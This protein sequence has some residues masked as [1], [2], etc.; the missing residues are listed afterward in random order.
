MYALQFIMLR[1]KLK[2]DS[3]LHFY[4]QLSA[5]VSCVRLAFPFK[6]YHSYYFYML[7]WNWKLI[8]SSKWLAFLKVLWGYM[9]LL[10]ISTFFKI[11]HIKLRQLQ[12]AWGWEPNRLAQVVTLLMYL[13]GA[14]LESWPKHQLSRQVISYTSTVHPANARIVS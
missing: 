2:L 4:E 13:W 9:H 7:H 12:L 5:K 3:S 14:Q 1:T 8:A 11:F 10:H 6:H